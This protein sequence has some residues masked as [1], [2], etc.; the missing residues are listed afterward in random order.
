MGSPSHLKLGGCGHCIRV[1]KIECIYVWCVF[2]NGL[3]TL[4]Y[5]C[6]STGSSELLL[7]ARRAVFCGRGVGVF[8]VVV[9]T[10][11][12]QHEMQYKNLASLYVGRLQYGGLKIIAGFNSLRC[13]LVGM[14]RYT[15]FKASN[16]VFVTRTQTQLGHN[17]VYT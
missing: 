17:D 6:V 1:F 11:H 16:C 3:C 13:L 8:T 5:L 15:L 7:K 9:C 14:T 12:P 10:Q 2:V 4:V